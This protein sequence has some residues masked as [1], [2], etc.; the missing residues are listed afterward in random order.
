[1]GCSDSLPPI[2][3]RFV[4]FAWRYHTGDDVFVDRPLAAPVGPRRTPDGPGVFRCRLPLPALGVETTGSPRFLG[5]PQRAHALLFDPGGTGHA[6]LDFFYG[7]PMRPSELNDAVG[8]HDSK[9]FGAQSHGLHTRCLRFAVRVAPTP[10]KTRF[11]LLAR[12]CR[13]GLAARWV[14]NVRFPRF[15]LWRHHRSPPYPGFAWRTVYRFRAYQRERK[16]PR[17][18]LSPF[19]LYPDVHRDR[20]RRSGRTPALPYPPGRHQ[21]RIHRCWAEGKCCWRPISGHRDLPAGSP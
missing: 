19:P 5:G 13:A 10:R 2:P 18:H 9:P 21:T 16:R 15:F 3:P 1:M 12:L 6:R 17:P 20:P 11:R 8:S 7:A 4:A 14:L